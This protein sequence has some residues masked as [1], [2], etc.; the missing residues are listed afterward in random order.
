MCHD[1][2][3]AWT[4]STTCRQPSRRVPLLR[5][6]KPLLRR[7]STFNSYRCQT[8]K[9]LPGTPR[10]RSGGNHYTRLHTVHTAQLLLCP[11]PVHMLAQSFHLRMSQLLRRVNYWASRA[12][13]FSVGQLFEIPGRPH[14][15]WTLRDYGHPCYGPR[16]AGAKLAREDFTFLFRSFE[17]G[18]TPPHRLK[19]GQAHSPTIHEYLD[20]TVTAAA[21]AVRS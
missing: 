18:Q 15:V 11:T 5:K 10:G 20:W 13:V 6:T 17:S 21:S 19:K 3:V 8:V 1:R 16:P 7:I 12:G 4:L 2:P 14:V 9:R